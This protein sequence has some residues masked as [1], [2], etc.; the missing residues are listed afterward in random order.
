MAGTSKTSFCRL[1]ELMVRGTD[2]EQA[3]FD[4][5]VRN[6]KNGSKLYGRTE[7][8]D[9]RKLL[10]EF[11]R[12][13]RKARRE[14]SRFQHPEHT[15]EADETLREA[16]EKFVSLNEWRSNFPPGVLKRDPEVEFVE[17][18]FEPALAATRRIRMLGE[19]LAQEIVQEDRRRR[20]DGTKL[21][22]NERMLLMLKEDRSRYHWSMQKWATVFDSARSTI[23]KKKA[24]DVIMEH[25][26]KRDA[27]S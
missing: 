20:S 8:A 12:L 14:T 5:A 7:I 25:R 15:N 10:L 1:C 4:S 6:A 2:F 27:N 16:A 9:R 26:N 13:W 24:W 11:N 22:I 18:L 19:R 3:A 17:R 21:N 23:G